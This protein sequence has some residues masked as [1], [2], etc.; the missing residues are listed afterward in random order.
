MDTAKEFELLYNLL[1]RESHT[2]VTVNHELQVPFLRGMFKTIRTNTGMNTV[3]KKIGFTTLITDKK[4]GLPTN[5]LSGKLLRYLF[6]F[7]GNN[8]SGQN[9]LDSATTRYCKQTLPSSTHTYWISWN[10]T[11]GSWTFQF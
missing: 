1:G 11:R 8:Y 4:H 10:E 2:H 3:L 7:Q 6:H 9:Q 5:F